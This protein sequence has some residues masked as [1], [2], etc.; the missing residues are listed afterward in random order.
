MQ[1]GYVGESILWSTYKILHSAINHTTKH[2]I[3]D[4]N[5]TRGL[6]ENLQEF[7][8]QP[9]SWNGSLMDILQDQAN[10]MSME[11]VKMNTFQKRLCQ[12]IEGFV[13]DTSIF[14]NLEFGNNNLS[15]LLAKIQADGQLWEQ[16]LHTTGGEL[17]LIQR[18]VTTSHKTLG[19]HKCIVG[20]GADH[21]NY[22]QDKSN[23][24]ALLTITSQM[25]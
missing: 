22:L 15:E 4:K 5:S 13:V 2:I 23:K 10:G 20:K 3:Q 21:C 16:L 1:C 14:A 17:E 24:I 18:E 12:W 9:N 25:N 6:F 7:I 11:Y 8:E 19:T